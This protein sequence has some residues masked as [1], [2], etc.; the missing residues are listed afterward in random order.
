[1][2]TVELEEM[3]DLEEMADKAVMDNKME[4]LLTH[5]PS[6]ITTSQV[7]AQVL[8][9]HSIG[10]PVTGPEVVRSLSWLEAVASEAR[11]HTTQ[12]PRARLQ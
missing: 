1:M 9:I 10:G 8:S 5:G 12:D 2:E 4:V 11:S 7:L 3:V 6:S